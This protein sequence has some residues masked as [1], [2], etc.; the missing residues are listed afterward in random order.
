MRRTIISAVIGF[1]IA[2]A[3]I[4]TIDTWRD[5]QRASRFATLQEAAPSEWLRL[6]DFEATGAV[7]PNEPIVRFIGTPAQNLLIRLAISSRNS[8]TGN[9]LCSGGSQ[10]VLYEAGVPVT[11]NA[12][13][14]RLA[15]L[16]ACE[17]PVGRYTV[18]VTFLMTEPQS[19]IAKTLLVETNDI[20]VI[21]PP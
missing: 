16:D 1:G 17:W 15:G 13:V 4:F 20:E 21:A 11:V 2:G 19:Q 7:S 8:D 9:V 6:E 12:P 14:S 18:R 10:T 5:I 3:A